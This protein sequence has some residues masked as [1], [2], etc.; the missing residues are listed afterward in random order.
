MIITLNPED[1][2]STAS[3]TSVFSHLT[4]WCN[5]PENDNFHF[6]VFL[7]CP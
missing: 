1:G 4:T 7:I 2:G 5:N 3:E 6:Y